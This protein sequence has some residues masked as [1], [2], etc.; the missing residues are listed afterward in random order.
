[1]ALLKKIL[2]LWNDQKGAALFIV[3]TAMVSLL[4]FTALV[5]DIGLIAANRQKLLN[6]VDAAA[7]SGAQELPDTAKAVTTARN[8]ALYN[9]YVPAH[10][11]D[12]DITVADGKIT[13]SCSKNISLA[14]ARLF[15]FHSRTVTATATARVQALTSFKGA[16]PLTVDDVTLEN[17]RPHEEFRLKTDY[18]SIGSGNF[19]ALS[20]GTDDDYD[21]KDPGASSYRQNLKKGSPQTIRVGDELLTKPGN[22]TGPTGQ[23]LK[24]RIDGCACTVTTYINHADCPR[25]VLIPVYHDVPYS[26]L[27]GRTVIR[28]AGFASVFI[29]RVNGSNVYARVLDKVLKDGESSATQTDYGVTK[30][31]L[32]K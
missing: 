19:G 28:V 20:L 10:S 12:P 13:V 25:V 31:V 15:G 22:M 26:D 2:H 29:T 3:A 27:N 30:P 16:L 18:P 8:Y 4:G 17:L 24:D 1:M 21:A 6:I 9:N 5:T 14:F 7:L 23:G 11:G 32:I